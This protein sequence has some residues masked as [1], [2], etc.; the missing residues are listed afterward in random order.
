MV[1]RADNFLIITRA[2][3]EC[4]IMLNKFVI[5][6]SGID[7]TCPGSRPRRAHCILHVSSVMEQLTDVN[8]DNLHHI[9]QHTVTTRT[10]P[11]TLLPYTGSL[12]LI[13]LEI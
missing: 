10:S 4:S 13:K 1:V 3:G 5:F 9:A 12:I 7:R 8:T 6:L 2:I 11:F